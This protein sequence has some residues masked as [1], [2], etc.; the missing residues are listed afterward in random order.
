MPLTTKPSTEMDLKALNAG[1]FFE[2]RPKNREQAAALCNLY[3]TSINMT[4][5]CGA[6]HPNLTPAERTIIKT[7]RW[8]M[9]ELGSV[10]TVGKGDG[11]EHP[12]NRLI[13]IGKVAPQDEGSAMAFNEEL[14]EWL[15]KNDNDGKITLPGGNRVSRK[16][17]IKW[18]Q[19]SYEEATWN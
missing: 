1:D 12:I 3:A 9:K 18:F 2:K 17:A 14:M 11:E 6:L 8:M 19:A 13:P 10:L 4:L 16:E 15:A 5:Q 7:M